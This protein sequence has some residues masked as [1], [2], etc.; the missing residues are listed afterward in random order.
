M[1]D[2]ISWLPVGQRS[3]FIPYRERF[4]HNLYGFRFAEKCSYC[5]FYKSWNWFEERY[6]YS[7]PIFVSTVNLLHFVYCR[8][9]FLNLF[10]LIAWL[11]W[12]VTTV[13]TS[14][15]AATFGPSR[16]LASLMATFS[17][18]VA[19]SDFKIEYGKR[20]ILFCSRSSWFAVHHSD[21]FN[22]FEAE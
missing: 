19:S 4:C 15:L 7:D 8:N 5:T 14:R 13:S 17:D 1:I 3:P 20:I 9:E 16:S 18:V 11:V 2:R 12:S 10:S 21:N 6:V 22:I